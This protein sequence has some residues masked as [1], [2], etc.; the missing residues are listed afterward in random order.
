MAEI[1]S[2]IADRLEKAKDIDGEV[3]TIIN[4]IVKNHKRVIFNGNNYAD[5][6]VK[7]AEKRGLPNIKSTVE[8]IPAWITE[9][10]I[11]LFD[12]HAVLSKIEVHSR[13]E[14]YLEN[15]IKQVNIEALTMLDMA[16]RQII[17]VVIQYTGEVAAAINKVKSAAPKASLV[18]QEKLLVE[19]TNILN[20]FN[21]HV[22]ALE[23]AIE[24]AP[25]GETLKLAEYYRDQVFTT[26]GKLRIDGDKLETLVDARIWPFPTYADMLFN[27]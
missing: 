24:A 12:E 19:T 1:L 26:M 4:E 23:K 25:E 7:E 9:K 8:A 5:E 20:S 27:V 14:I 6:W 2:Q 17:P 11:K 3:Q 10:S 21:S 16:K 22:E 18:A 15:Y 13:F